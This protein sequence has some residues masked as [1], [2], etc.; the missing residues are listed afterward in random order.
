MTVSEKIA[1]RKAKI[2]AA[3]ARIAKENE[4]ISK[5]NSE[6]ETMENL[7]I[8]ALIKEIDVPLDQVKALLEN[9][10]KTGVPTIDGQ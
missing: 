3:K 2:D 7:E 6:I 10:K 5:W 4:K 8:K 9:L 1:D